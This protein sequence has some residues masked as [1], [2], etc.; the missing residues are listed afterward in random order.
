MIDIPGRFGAASKDA[1]RGV[2]RGVPPLV[3]WGAAAVVSLGLWVLLLSLAGR[4]F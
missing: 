1:K 4:L 3:G 2:P